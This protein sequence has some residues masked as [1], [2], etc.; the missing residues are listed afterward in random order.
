M[1][2][3]S[4][5]VVVVAHDRDLMK[6]ARSPLQIWSSTE[7]QL[8]EVDIGSYFSDAFKDERVADAGRGARGVQGRLPHG[9]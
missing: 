6:V 4:D 1:Q 2:E 8:R 7:K 9:H 5:G 3:S